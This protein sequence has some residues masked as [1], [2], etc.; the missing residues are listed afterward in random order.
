MNDAVKTYIVYALLNNPTDIVDVNSSAFIVD[1]TRWT[2]IDE[3]VGDK[4]HHAQG[5]YFDKTIMTDSGI[6][7]YK[8]VNGAPI[9]KTDNEIANEEALLPA[10][11]PTDSDRISTLEIEN[12]EL[13]IVIDTM[14][15]GGTA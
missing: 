6:Y 5:N 8:L 12:A 15:T 2:Q 14:L 11:A 9:E 10:P 4:Y 1:T 13:K 7:R 3:G